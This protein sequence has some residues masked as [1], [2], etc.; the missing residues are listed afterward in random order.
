MAYELNGIQIIRD[1]REMAKALEHDHTIGF[2]T[3][4][5][6]LS[7]WRDRIALMQF[8]GDESGALGA[9]QI[10]NGQVP[11]ELKDLFTKDRTFICHNAV[12]FDILMLATHDVPWQECNWYDTLVGETVCVSTGR[13]DIR[14]NLK[15]ATHRRLGVTLDK[16]IE[17]GHWHEELSDEQLEYATQDVAHLPALM[18]AQIQKAVETNQL[19]ALQLECEIMPY[20]ARMTVNGLP[21]PVEKMREFIAVQEQ[22]LQ[23]Y[24]GKMI[25]TFGDINFNS[26]VQIKKAIRQIFGMRWESTAEPALLDKIYDD[27]IAAPLAQLILNYR[28]PAQRLKMYDDDFIHEHIINDFIHARFWQCSADTGRFTCSNPNL[29]QV[30]RDGRWFIGSRPGYDLVSVDYSQIEVRVAAYI[31]GDQALMEVLDND[32]VHRSVASLI[33][34]TPAGLVTKEQRRKAKA[35]VFALLYCGGVTRLYNQARQDG[36]PMTME[37]ANDVFTAFF[38]K[39]QGL[40]KM[41]LKAIAMSKNNRMNIVRMPSGLR[42]VLMGMDN[43]PSVILNNTVQG[44]A[45]AGLKQGMRIAGKHGLFEYIG[46]QVHDELVA[47]VPQKQSRD[48]GEALKAD[49]IEGMGLYLPVT[50]KAEVKSGPVWQ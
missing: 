48:F 41:R 19:E 11:Q 9:I 49:M 24:H 29:Q 22:E 43:R 1:A 3:E 23:K 21:C 20:V 8:Y 17:H 14:K 28:A 12:A 35:A 26:H 2:D 16:G 5:T 38:S 18:R 27:P 30:P 50:V 32:D 33:F 46:A 4:T 40:W 34:Q 37:E 42:R 36:S 44:F 10:K 25:A 7:P 15:S 39:F 31:S 47:S 45:A 13:K 6:G